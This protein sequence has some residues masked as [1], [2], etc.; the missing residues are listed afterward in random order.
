VLG[1][2]STPEDAHGEMLARSGWLCFRQRPAESHGG[3]S[4]RC[5]LSGWKSAGYGTDDGARQR[6]LWIAQVTFTSPDRVGD[7]ARRN[8]NTD[9]P[10]LRRIVERAN[11]A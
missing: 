11:A 5:K 3:C 6:L 7:V 9:N 2:G 4:C 8:R 1:L 10:R